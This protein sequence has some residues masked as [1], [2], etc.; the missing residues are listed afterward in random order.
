MQPSEP[1]Y[2]QCADKYEIKAK[3]VHVSKYENY[4]KLLKENELFCIFILKFNH[5]IAPQMRQL[6]ESYSD[7]D[8]VILK[9]PRQAKKYLENNQIC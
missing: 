3:T 2:I 5:T 7:K 6:L 1:S 4:R 9:N 8:V